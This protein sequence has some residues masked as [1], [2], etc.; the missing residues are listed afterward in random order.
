M[1]ELCIQQKE[2]NKQENTKTNTVIDVILRQAL[3]PPPYS[4]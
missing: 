3:P 2:T 1:F 4:Y